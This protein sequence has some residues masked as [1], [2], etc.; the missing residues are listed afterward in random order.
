MR[1]VGKRHAMT[2]MEVM[3]P[4]PEMTVPPLV[5]FILSMNFCEY[6]WMNICIDGSQ[7]L[8]KS[9]ISIRLTHES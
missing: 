4:V 3:V 9:F 8:L 5:D 7:Q 2:A 1:D 6:S